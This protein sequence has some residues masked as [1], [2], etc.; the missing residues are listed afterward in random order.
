MKNAILLHGKGD[1]PNLFWF[2]YI[3][4]KLEEMNYEVWAPEL[5]NK[6]HPNLKDQLTF[7]LES[8]KFSEETILIGHSKS[9][10]LILHILEAINIQI[11][12][13]VLVS[14]YAEPLPLSN[15]D[16]TK[17]DFNWNKIKIGSKDF[18]F[19]NSDNDPWGCDDVQGRIFFDNLGGTLI[20]R[21]GE[22]HMG[23]G[24]YNQPYKEFPLLAKLIKD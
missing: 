12:Q 2:P 17:R 4:Q 21:H 6:E 14:G 7:I 18:I 11:K 20:I 10:S 22:G 19:I 3:K 5:P 1:G 9:C 24:T 15:E 23:S 8:A 13:V 16:S